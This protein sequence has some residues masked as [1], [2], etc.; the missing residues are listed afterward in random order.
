MRRFSFHLLMGMLKQ[1]IT[2]VDRN[3]NAFLWELAFDILV[4]RELRSEADGVVAINPQSRWTQKDLVCLGVCKHDVGLLDTARA[5]TNQF[6]EESPVPLVGRS[7]PL[8]RA[9]T[10]HKTVVEHGR[11]LTS[12]VFGKTCVGATE[13]KV[14]AQRCPARYSSEHEPRR[15][16]Q[17]RAAEPG[18]R[19][20][21]YKTAESS[22]LQ[23]RANLRGPMLKPPSQRGVEVGPCL[24]ASRR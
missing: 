14:V 17:P 12:Q 8:W 23:P 7:T 4:D 21:D 11:T 19:A 9:I 10:V 15:I 24:D 18:L 22:A 20:G 13:P 1:Q 16:R 6:G 2:E 5:F 3:A